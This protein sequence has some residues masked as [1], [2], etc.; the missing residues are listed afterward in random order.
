MPL[1][2]AHRSVVE[3]QAF[4]DLTVDYETGIAYLA[5]DDRSWW[6]QFNLSV[7]TTQQQGSLFQFDI[8]AETFKKLK[9]ID[10]PYEH[11]HPLGL[12][13]LD[14]KV[15]SKTLEIADE[16]Q[17]IQLF[18]TNYRTD[19]GR[20]LGAVDIFAIDSGDADHAQWIDSVVHPLFTG[21][22]FRNES[23]KMT[24]VLS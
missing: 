24:R 21:M 19:N 3:N 17:S 16:R 14:G 10:Y 9:L 23:F 2:W 22:H 6:S 13:L 7:T 12:G 20:I 8:R 4:E 5:G 1:K 18:T 15:S 11:F